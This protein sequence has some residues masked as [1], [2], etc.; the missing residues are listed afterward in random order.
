M[1]TILVL[2]LCTLL[3]LSSTQ[4]VALQILSA[5]DSPTTVSKSITSSLRGGRYVYLKVMGHSPDPTQNLI[6]IN[7]L[8]CK[9][10][11]D[12]VTDTFITCVT[13]DTGSLSSIYSKPI[14]LVS[15]TGTYTTPNLVNFLQSYTPQLYDIFPSGSFGSSI[16][17]FYGIHRIT[18]LGDGLRSMGDIYKLLL[19]T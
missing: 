16:V 10:P 9:I 17:K 15:S 18:N 19:G 7:G 4:Q 2:L 11:S 5:S 1:K 3:A 12:G 8:P 14:I 6:F 13:P